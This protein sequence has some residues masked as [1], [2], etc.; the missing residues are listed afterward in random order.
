MTAIHNPVI[1]NKVV[2]KCS[3]TSIRLEYKFQKCTISFFWIALCTVHLNTFVPYQWYNCAL[4]NFKIL[5]IQLKFQ[6]CLYKHS[7]WWSLTRNEQLTLT[8]WTH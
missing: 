1:S 5:Y 3:K 8:S 4:S 6:T 2:S 7:L